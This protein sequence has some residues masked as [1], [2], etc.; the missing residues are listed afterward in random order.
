MRTRLHR[1]AALAALVALGTLPGLAQASGHAPGRAQIRSAVAR[2][3]RSR[4]LWAT[5]NVCDTP[6][7]PSTIGIRGQMPALGFPAR[8]Y[9]RIEVQYLSLPDKHFRPAP[10]ASKWIGLGQ[11]RSGVRQGGV[12]FR[13]SAHAGLLRGSV[14]FQWKL[15]TRVI[16]QLT[17][18]TVRGHPGADY[19]DPPHHSLG[20]CLIS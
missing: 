4:N 9:M 16:G 3:E 17:Q 6:R 10:G 15:G 11:R 18:A 13:F 7:H 14:R 19:G 1:A 20:T 2:A 12:L 5:V 8:L